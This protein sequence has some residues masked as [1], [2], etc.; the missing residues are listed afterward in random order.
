[1]TLKSWFGTESEIQYTSKDSDIEATQN[2]P[3]GG[4]GIVSRNQAWHH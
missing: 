3:E 1:M 4:S 2:L